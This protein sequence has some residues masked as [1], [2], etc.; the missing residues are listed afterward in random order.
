MGRYEGG[1]GL[2]WLKIGDVVYGWPLALFLTIGPFGIKSLSL[3]YVEKT[4]NFLST[5]LPKTL[6]GE[7][8]GHYLWGFVCSNGINDNALWD[9]AAFTFAWNRVLCLLLLISGENGKCDQICFKFAS[10]GQKPKWRNP[11]IGYYIQKC[12]H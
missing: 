4:Q 9:Y 10:F 2:K 11:P 3:R 5:T 8:D 7:F 12:H 1:R 6:W